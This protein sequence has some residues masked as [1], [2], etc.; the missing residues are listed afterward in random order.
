MNT[1]NFP[2]Y[3]LSRRSGKQG[4]RPPK[5]GNQAG[6]DKSATRRLLRCKID[7]LVSTFTADFSAVYT[8]AF[9]DI[10]RRSWFDQVTK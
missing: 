8:P 5:V 2:T 9:S 4:P 3:R 7:T 1:A 6:E 10:I